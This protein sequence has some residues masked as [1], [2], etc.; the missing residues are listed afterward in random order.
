ML[1]VIDSGSQAWALAAADGDPHIY[2]REV[3]CV[4]RGFL[5]EDLEQIDQE[6]G[7]ILEA[8]YERYATPDRNGQAAAHDDE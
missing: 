7:S 4:V 2:A 3:R 8:L 5:S 1:T 6:G